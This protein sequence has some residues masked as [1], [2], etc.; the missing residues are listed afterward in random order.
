MTYLLCEK[1]DDIYEAEPGI[2]ESNGKSD[3]IAAPGSKGSQSE[4][5][6]SS[7]LDWTEKEDKRTPHPKA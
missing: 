6:H 2:L 3:K 5:V 4:G 1:P 7:R